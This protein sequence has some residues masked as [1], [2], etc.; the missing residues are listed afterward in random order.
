V[1]PYI[2]L[3]FE[4]TDGHTVCVDPLGDNQ[5]DRNVALMICFLPQIYG[6]EKGELIRDSFALVH[7]LTLP[8]LLEQC[9]QGLFWLINLACSSL[10]AAIDSLAF[11]LSAFYR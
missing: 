8:K 7:R 2:S 6:N 11:H 3:Y 4:T 9:A 10:K 5:K 1:F